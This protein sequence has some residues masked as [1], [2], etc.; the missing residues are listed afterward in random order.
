MK[1]ENGR[2]SLKIYQYKTSQ[3]VDFPVNKIIMEILKKYHY[4]F[5]PKYNAKTLETFERKFNP[6]LKKLLEKL[7][8]KR[9]VTKCKRMKKGEKNII[10]DFPICEVYS[11]HDNRRTFATYFEGKLERS[12]IMKVTGHKKESSYL[13]Y[14]G[15]V[16]VD[17]DKIR[18]VFD[19]TFNTITK[20]VNL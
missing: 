4:D 18:A 6:L 13:R 9:V 14:V 7:E 3:L 5:P 2:Y 15:A 10:G 8:I 1:D 12:L 20:T 11:S 16:D 17:K 19:E